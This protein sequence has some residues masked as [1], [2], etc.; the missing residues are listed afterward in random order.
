MSNSS[1]WTGYLTSNGSNVMSIEQFMASNNASYKSQQMPTIEAVDFNSP[2]SRFGPNY[3]LTI[4]AQDGDLFGNSVYTSTAFGTSN[5]SHNAFSV[6][7]TD[8][9]ATS[10]ELSII[11]IAQIFDNSS[12]D[13]SEGY[14]AFAYD[15]ALKQLL[16]TVSSDQPYYAV[17]ESTIVE[18][19]RDD[20]YVDIIELE[21]AMSYQRLDTFY[22]ITL[23]G[24][25]GLTLS[26]ELHEYFLQTYSKYS[27]HLPMYAEIACMLAYEEARSMVF[28]IISMQEAGDKQL[29]K[30]R[31]VYTVYEVANSNVGDMDGYQP[32]A[33]MGIST[34]TSG[35]NY[36]LH[37]F[38]PT[39]ATSEPYGGHQEAIQVSNFVQPYLQTENARQAAIWFA[40][41][42][43]IN[44]TGSTL[45]I[46]EYEEAYDCFVLL[47]YT[48]A[49]A[50][51]AIISVIMLYSK[52][53]SIYNR[54]ILHSIGATIY[55]PALDDD[56][57]S[58]KYSYELAYAQSTDKKSPALQLVGVGTLEAHQRQH[59][60]L[61]KLELLNETKWRMNSVP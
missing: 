30:L 15:S 56:E 48:A 54:D 13:T 43:S 34:V 50:M 19:R 17:A 9:N 26:S 3:T 27:T 37:T 35:Y 21:A 42:A 8:D 39:I 7:Y 52:R 28:E 18:T 40:N 16:G 60:P 1:M 23:E 49:I 51:L 29:R 24:P 41:G 25:G 59:S 47:L 11:F 61:E 38:T 46:T 58:I 14:T 53:Y 20:D 45:L 31:Y 55:S 36:L 33:Y 5:N 22:N 6:I 2:N 10:S 57:S 12:Y 32:T 4:S 44:N